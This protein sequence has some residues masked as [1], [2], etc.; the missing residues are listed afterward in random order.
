MQGSL[1]F[2]LVTEYKLSLNVKSSIFW[3]HIHRIPI[4]FRRYLKKMFYCYNKKINFPQTLSLQF[5]QPGKDL[6]IRNGIT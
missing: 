2:S 6:N 1:F 5:V 3:Y 4:F